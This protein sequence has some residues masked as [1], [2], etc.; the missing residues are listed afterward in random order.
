[1]ISKEELMAMSA[2]ELPNSLGKKDYHD[3]F[4]RRVDGNECERVENYW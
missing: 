1:M 4:K 2:K 3:D